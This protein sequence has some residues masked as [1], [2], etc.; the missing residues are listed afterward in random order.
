MMKRIILICGMG[1]FFMGLI[2]QDLENSL[3]WKVEKEGKKPSY[4]FGTIHVLPQA[5][6]ELD[7]K[8]K[9]AIEAS[10][11][12]VL[13]MDMTDPN[14]QT[15]MFSNMNMQGGMTLDKL[16]SED[17]YK[18]LGEKLQSIQGVPPI[19]MVN[20]MKPFMLATLMIRE[21]VGSQPASFE[22]TLMS[23]AAAREMPVSG[24]ETIE[25]QMAIFDSIPYEDQ[26]KDLMDMV[27]KSE[28]MKALFAE[29]VG[30]YKDEEVNDLFN[31][32]EEYMNSEEEMKFLLYER[33]VKWAEKLDVMLGDKTYFIGV[34]A[35][36]LGGEQGLINLLQDQGYQLTPVMD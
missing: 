2:A 29:M 13:E 36:H 16:L 3:L 31:S 22:M 8:V 5:D 19:A 34:G 11:E 32:T 20:G 24:L 26:A 1:F 23:M 4:I 28:D 17:E 27:E 6:F 35:A 10:D 18:Q 21:Y 7:K 12:L 14:L 30:Q 33:N 25:S 9:T 15:K